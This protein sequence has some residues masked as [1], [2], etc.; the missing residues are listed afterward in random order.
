MQI[1]AKIPNKML[2][3]QIQPY[4][5]RIIRHDQL[6]VFLGIQG[7]FNVKIKSISVIYHTNRLKKKNSHDH[8]IKHRKKPLKN[9]ILFMIKT[10]SNLG[11]EGDFP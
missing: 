10:L 1:D 8:L 4:V 2:A 7:W 9:S 6:G 3:N 11:L 5:Q